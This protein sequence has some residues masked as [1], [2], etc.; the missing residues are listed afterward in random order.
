M[1]TLH[2]GSLSR[3]F[4]SDIH[5]RRARGGEETALL[6][7]SAKANT[8]A[9]VAVCTAMVG[10]I[11][12]G[13]DQGN[14]GNVQGF[15]SFRDHWCKGKYDKEDPL[16]CTEEG[17]KNNHGWQTEFIL[18]GG[19][20]ITL[21]AAAGGLFLG[22]VITNK[23]G[24]RLCIST[25]AAV[26]FI[27]CLLASY[28]SF[29]SIVVFMIGRFVT[30]FGV[31]VCCF[32]LPMYNSEIATPAIRGTLGSLFQFNVVLGGFIATVITLLSQDWMIGMMLPGIAGLLVAIAVWFTPESPRYVMAQKGYAAGV[33]VLQK[34]RR[35]D[36]TL[37]AQA[38]HDQMEEESKAGMVSY[39]DMFSHRSL[40][41]R[42]FIACYLQIAQQLTGVNAFLS[43]AN[44]LFSGV[45][46]QN[47]YVFNCIWNGV[48]MAGCIVGLLLIDSPRGGRR[49]QLLGSTVLMGPPL[50]V[51]GF[52]FLYNWPGVLEMIMVCV[53]GLGFQ[54]SW[55]M[56]PWVYPSEIFN[57]AEKDK[58][59]S[60]AVFWQYAINAAVAICTPVFLAWSMGGTLII[61]GVLNI[62]N[63]VFVIFFV[64]E[65]KGVP[66]ED[67]P[68]LFQ[69]MQSNSSSIASG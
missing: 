38:I 22:P 56:I 27:G 36:V 15:D 60:L 7:D 64:K 10:A 58:A 59:L 39:K 53:F 3:S 8:T 32:A 9:Y 66:L 26:C 42:V 37:E 30:G 35:G 50:L 29:D 6:A 14:F 12:F 2:T 16:A 47:P 54:L 41:K 63:F 33:A 20:L 13:L 25:G 31:G 45:G 51:A 5:R 44:T 34:V 4:G 68:A 67:V 21:G 43:Y 11:M 48:M 46:I 40:R 1:A 55:G 23:C 19:S 18:W 17:V 52:A 62:T 61:F 49:I 65:T 57:M 24:R 28:L 69:T